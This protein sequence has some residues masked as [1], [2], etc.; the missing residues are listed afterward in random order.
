[1]LRKQPYLDI[2]NNCVPRLTILKMQPYEFCRSCQNYQLCCVCTLQALAVRVS[3]IGVN[4]CGAD[5]CRLMMENALDVEQ[6]IRACFSYTYCTLI[7]G[8]ACTRKCIPVKSDGI[9]H[10]T[11][12][13][14]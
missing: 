11:Q 7:C 8:T 5:G 10:R 4:V 1:M 12:V 9:L 6:L 14:G 3:K 2:L 13:V